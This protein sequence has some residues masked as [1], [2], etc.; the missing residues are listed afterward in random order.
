MRR[1]STAIAALWLALLSVLVG[2]CSIQ[3][4]GAPSGSTNVYATFDDVQDLTPGHNVQASNVVVGSVRDI[5]L[6][7][8]RARVRMSIV[9]DFRVPE[10]TSAVV[11]RT[12]L[13]GEYYVDLVLPDDTGAP[14]SRYLADGDVI[15]DATTQPDFEQ[16]AEEAASVVGALTADDLAATIDAAAVGLGGRGQKLNQLVR[17]AGQVVGVL[18]D[19][20]A[21]IAATVDSL[22]ALGAT[23]APEA[24]RLAGT[25]DRLAEASSTVAASRDRVVA[26]MGALVELA[27]ATNDVIIVPHAQRIAD[28]L[29]DLEPTLG[30]LADRTDT[31]AQL[32]V[33][34]DR[35]VAILPSAVH[36]EVLLLMA[37]GYL[38]TALDSSPLGGAADPLDAL[39][40]LAGGA[41]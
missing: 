26:T 32:I 24:D 22:A 17:D 3:T 29:H 16:L 1:P 36:N 21:A 35:F 34:L 4:A 40:R 18:D 10:G 33:N 20:Q 30:V 6:D 41:P 37:W 25:I 39:A 2:A 8:H 27:K 28:L 19:Q 11:R 31:L 9:D 38:P 5:A 13:L 12:S 23:L 7:G 14:G 15:D